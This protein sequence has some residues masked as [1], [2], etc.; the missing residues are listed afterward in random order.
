MKYS[1]AHDTKMIRGYRPDH[2]YLKGLAAETER[3]MQS[4]LNEA[5]ALLRKKYA[6]PNSESSELPVEQESH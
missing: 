2:I 5:V 1:D 6:K 3:T 4:V